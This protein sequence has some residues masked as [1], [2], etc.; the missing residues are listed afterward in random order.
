ME[1]EQQTP[2]KKLD[3]SQLELP[4]TLPILPLHGF[5]F[6]PG[7]GLDRKSVV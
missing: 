5:V 2:P 1:Q 4:E 6:Y 3:P 7:M